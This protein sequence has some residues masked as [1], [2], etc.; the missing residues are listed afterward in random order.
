MSSL[1]PLLLCATRLC[2]ICLYLCCHCIWVSGLNSWTWSLLSV[3][4]S[5]FQFIT[6]NYQ[7]QFI[8]QILYEIPQTMCTE[9]SNAFHSQLLLHSS[10]R[11]TNTKRNNRAPVSLLSQDLKCS[12]YFH[13]FILFRKAKSVLHCWHGQMVKEKCT[14]R[15]VLG[16]PK[17]TSVVGSQIKKLTGRNL[18]SPSKTRCIFQEGKIKQHTSTSLNSTFNENMVLN[19]VILSFI[20]FTYSKITKLSFSKRFLFPKSL[21]NYFLHTCQSSS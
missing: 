16:F 15:E 21:E 2:C 17:C 6:I 13:F 11:Q 1:M 19:F 14:S 5:Y 7:I 9:V 3:H 20:Q 10:P 4:S 8:V 18:P 12:I